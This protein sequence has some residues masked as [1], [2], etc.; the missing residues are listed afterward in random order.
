MS[1]ILIGD[2][3]SD[4]KVEFIGDDSIFNNVTILAGGTAV[5]ARRIFIMPSQNPTLILRTAGTS[6]ATQIIM[7]VYYNAFDAAAIQTITIT[8][9]DFFVANGVV[10][11]LMDV[12]GAP[13]PMIYGYVD[14]VLHENSGL[15]PLNNIYGRVYLEN[16]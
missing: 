7:R 4:K 8:V 15:A 10:I 5:S 13:V 6:G 1:R 12:A 2:G 3:F 14:I 9:H 16:N 11:P